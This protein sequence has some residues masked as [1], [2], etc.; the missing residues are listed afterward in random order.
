MSQI[1][2]GAVTLKGNPVDLSGPELKPGTKAPEF[3]L[4]NNSLEE[5]TLA[6]SAG[7]TRI[8][9]TIPSLDTSVCHAE[10]KKFN[11][12]AASLANVEILVVSMDLPFGQKRWCGAEQ[13]ESVKTLSAHRCTKF[14]DD[15]GVLIKGGPLDRCLA[16][17]VFVIDGQGV[18]RHVEY[19]RE[20]AD[21]PNYDAALAAAV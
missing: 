4:Q 7:K 6:S 5:V 14:G 19:V 20:I 16:R 9:A 18:I 21:H 17:A 2:A 13:V 12:K 8:I 1:R 10:T 15:Y 11:E 3:S